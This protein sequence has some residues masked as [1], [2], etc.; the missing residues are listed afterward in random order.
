MSHI[1]EPPTLGDL[2]GTL[3]GKQPWSIFIRE[4]LGAMIAEEIVEF[5]ASEKPTQEAPTALTEDSL[6]TPFKA[7]SS[8]AAQG[9]SFVL[10]IVQEPSLETQIDQALLS[11]HKKFL[12]KA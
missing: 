3:A 8:K 4:E 9:R 10:T 12:L 11:R 6:D 1:R 2:T 7:A 5:T